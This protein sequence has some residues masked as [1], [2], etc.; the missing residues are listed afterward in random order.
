MLVYHGGYTLINEIDLEKCRPY[1]DFGKGFYVTKYKNH[2]ENWA[3]KSGQ[4]YNTDGCVTVFNYTDSSFVDHICKKKYFNGYT[5]EWLDFIV[6]DKNIDTDSASDLY[7]SS[8]TF[9]DITD[10]KLEHYNK[11]TNEIY[12]MLMKELG[13]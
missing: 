7:F 4:H 11:D 2:A 3:K 5:E 6:N 10:K 1:T 12:K 9:A 8:K 13:S